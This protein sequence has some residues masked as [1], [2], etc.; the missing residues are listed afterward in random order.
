MRYF[1]FALAA[2][3]VC[4]AGAQIVTA[5]SV[6]NSK[7]EKAAIDIQ[8]LTLAAKNLPETVIVDLI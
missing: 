8:A 3:F 6:T 5:T 2:A 7:I 1:I 4:V